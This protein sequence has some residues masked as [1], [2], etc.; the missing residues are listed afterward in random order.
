MVTGITRAVTESGK[1]VHRITPRST[2]VSRR[3]KRLA[4]APWR[5]AALLLV[6]LLASTS[7]L[8][9]AAPETSSVA[10]NRTRA[11]DALAAGSWVVEYVDSTVPANTA[12]AYPSLALDTAGHPFISYVFPIVAASQVQLRLAGKLGSAWAIDSAVDP[13]A[14]IVGP[15]S[16]AL[17]GSNNP[18][19]AYSEGTG[20]QRV[21]FASRSG[22][23]WSQQ[24]VE[25]VQPGQA[26]QGDQ[27][28]LALTSTGSPRLA[29]VGDMFN[30]SGDLRFATQSGS[31]WSAGLVPGADFYANH[32]SLKLDSAGTA[33]VAYNYYNDSTKKRVLR[34]STGTGTWSHA[35]V[36]SDVGSSS[37]RYVA[38]ALDSLDRP[39][40]LYS[41]YD[42]NTNSY[43]LRY[44]HHNG[45]G[46]EAFEIIANGH[47]D[48]PAIAV[49][50][51]R[52]PHVCFYHWDADMTRYSHRANGV[53]TTEDLATRGGDCSI[54]VDSTGQPSLAWVSRTGSGRV[55]YASLGG[56]SQN[57]VYLPLVIRH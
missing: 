20:S 43:S 11:T 21:K 55:R 17:D 53:W 52:N 57:N 31:S 44:I 2:G 32:P 50:S 9:G 3:R 38:L 6:L 25:E 49:D 16:L 47:T 34:Y 4:D 26:H 24:I 13:V 45:N 14:M 15:T 54:A 46:W 27:P 7:A 36:V 23:A 12:A 40:I 5:G 33:R 39:H 51:D 56:G 30:A 29:Y 8:A 10:D 41:F 22:T 18:K 48:Q 1:M 35:T 42:S 19:V 37:D 28:S